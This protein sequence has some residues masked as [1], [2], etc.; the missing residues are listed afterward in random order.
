M[1]QSQ[2]ME[3]DHTTDELTT[4][5]YYGE[6][7]N[8]GY[9]HGLLKHLPIGCGKGFLISLM[10]EKNPSGVYFPDV[11]VINDEQGQEVSISHMS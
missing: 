7:N 10:A 8:E 3:Y 6:S 1:A 9:W 5:T 4:E 2:I 11:P